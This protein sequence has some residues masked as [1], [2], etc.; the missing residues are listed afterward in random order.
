MYGY[1]AAEITGHSVAELIPADRP[2]ELAEILAQLARGE[3]I[4]HFQTRRVCKD[5][6]VLDVSVSI[7]PVRDPAG[8]VTGFATVARD[9][10]D[11]T[12]AAA[13]IRAYQE[14]VSRTE[15]METVGQLAAGIAHDFNN[16]L[17]AIAGLADLIK[18]GEDPSDAS[19]DAQQ[20]LAAVERAG[21]LTRDLLL[22][23]RR[24]VTRPRHADLNTVVTGVRSL[25]GASLGPN[26]TLAVNLRTDLPVVWVD[27]GQVERAILNIAVNARDVMPDGGTLTI[28]T[29]GA[30]LEG[31]RPGHYAELTVTDTGSGMTPEVAA[32]VFEPFYTTKGPSLGSGLGLSTVYGIIAQASG[33]ITVASRPGVGTTFRILFPA[34][35]TVAGP[36][37]A[38]SPGAAEPLPTGTI[39]ITDDEEPILRATARMLKRDGYTPLEAATGYQALDLL[40]ANEVHL[41]LTDSLMPGMTGAELADRARQIRPGLPVLHMS[42][43]TPPQDPAHQASFIHKPF[44]AEQLLTKIRALLDPQSCPDPPSGTAGDRGGRTSC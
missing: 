4:E 6:S 31:A 32:H 25:L 35:A 17:G 14:Q 40:I 29:A 19:D 21:R 18:G 11:Q 15:R 24:A 33:T 8:R 26:I 37:P 38:P 10:T 12:R 5:G 7:S 13:Q 43:F 42:G 2:D 27:P 44:T 41:L 34:A 3:P 16:T 1:T 30:R 28:T 9:I 22:V 20:I 36:V 39:L 23:G